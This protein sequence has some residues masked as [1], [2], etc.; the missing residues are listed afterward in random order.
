LRV[1]G[2]KGVSLKEEI[3]GSLSL[4]RHYMVTEMIEGY[5]RKGGLLKRKSLKNPL[6]NNGSFIYASFFIPEAI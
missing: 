2:E 5:E 1:T 3:E 6:D 4:N